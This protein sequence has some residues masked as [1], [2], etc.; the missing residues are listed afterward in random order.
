MSEL[1]E[2]QLELRETIMLVQYQ[3][4]ELR[5]IMERLME[6]YKREEAPDLAVWIKAFTVSEVEP[7]K[8]D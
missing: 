1:T 6:D 7:F 4:N 5:G 3:I 2:R 8:E